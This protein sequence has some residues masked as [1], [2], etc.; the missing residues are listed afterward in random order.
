MNLTKLNSGNYLLTGYELHDN[1]APN[2]SCLVIVYFGESEIARKT[3]DKFGEYR[4]ELANLSP[5]KYTVKFFGG[6][7]LAKNQTEEDWKYFVIDNPADPSFDLTP[8]DGTLG[9]MFLHQ[10]I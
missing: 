4:F 3:T 8:P 1:G 6:G 2:A 7:R 10:L 5:G 9:G